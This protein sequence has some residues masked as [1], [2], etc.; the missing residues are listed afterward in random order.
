MFS[1]KSLLQEDNSLQ[2]PATAYFTKINCDAFT[3]FNNSQNVVQEEPTINDYINHI[4][5][6]TNTIKPLN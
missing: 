6:L 4:Y 1:Q 3:Q 2:L 5:K